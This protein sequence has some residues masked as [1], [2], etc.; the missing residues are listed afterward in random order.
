V[1]NNI[2]GSRSERLC[3]CD[4]PYSVTITVVDVDGR[5]TGNNNN[6]KGNFV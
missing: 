3:V 5:I 4:A 2:P 6:N 1:S